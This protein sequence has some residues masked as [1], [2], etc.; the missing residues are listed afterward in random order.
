MC[1]RD[2]TWGI[3]KNWVAMH[4]VSFKLDDV[5]RLVQDNC[6]NIG[7][8]EWEGICAKAKRIEEDYVRQ[9]VLTENYKVNFL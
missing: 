9:E 1:I 6:A 2:S 7:Q 4:N 3:L 8:N 5:T